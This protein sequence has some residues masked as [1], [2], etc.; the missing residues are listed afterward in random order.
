MEVSASSFGSAKIVDS[1][2]TGKGASFSLKLKTTVRV[3]DSDEKFKVCSD[4]ESDLI[5]CLRKSVDKVFERFGCDYGVEVDFSSEVPYNLGFKCS[6]INSAVLASIGLIAKKSG[7]IYNSFVFKNLREDKYSRDKIPEVNGKL[8]CDSEILSICSDVVSE[9]NLASECPLED[10]NASYSGGFYVA[11]NN[12]NKILR[13]GGNESLYAF[14][15]V[16]GE[17]NKKNNFV[18]SILKN[19]AD[20][21]FGES[22]KGNLYSAMN[23]NSLICASIYGGNFEA[24]NSALGAGAEACSLSGGVFVAVFRDESIKNKIRDKWS[25]FGGELIETEANNEKANLTEI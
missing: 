23:L 9:L 19:E 21:V 25:F 7:R 4:L 20:I 6:L 2:L 18:E 16:P 15:L 22:L 1:F 13:F 17:I 14:V 12:K 24:F 3:R 5:K 8:I 11:D 10:L